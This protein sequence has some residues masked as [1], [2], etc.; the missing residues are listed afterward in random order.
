MKD[1]MKKVERTTGCDKHIQDGDQNKIGF[2]IGS[3][4]EAEKDSKAAGSI[5]VVGSDT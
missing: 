2:V 3:A 1:C 4:G 5:K